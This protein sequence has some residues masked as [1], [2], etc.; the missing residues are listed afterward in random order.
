MA[1]Q[2]TSYYC[3]NAG[4]NCNSNVCK[5]GHT[6]MHYESLHMGLQCCFLNHYHNPASAAP[7]LACGANRCWQ[8]VIPTALEYISESFPYNLVDYTIPLLVRKP[9]KIEEW[10]EKLTHYA[11]RHYVNMILDIVEFGARIGYQGPIQQIL[12]E[13]LSLATNAPNIISQ[14][15]D[16]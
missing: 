8:P 15:L 10:K 6:C 4:A 16:N 3:Y 14:D 9:F 2:P 12:S 1:I 7:F 11:D 5:F 13:N